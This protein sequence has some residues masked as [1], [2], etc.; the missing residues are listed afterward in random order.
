MTINKNVLELLIPKDKE[1]LFACIGTDRSTGD[2]LGPLVGTAL[3]V[4]GYTVMGTLHFPV[5]AMNLHETVENIERN[6]PSHFIVA[7]DACLGKSE[8]VGLITVKKGSIKP[9][10]A[11]GKDLPLIGDVAITGIVNVGGFMEASVLQSTRLSKVMDM[12]DE[13]AYMCDAAMKRR[14]N[15]KKKRP[16]V[17]GRKVKHI[18]RTL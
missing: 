16:A 7:V 9:G 6:Y 17:T 11:V 14:A 2:S 8:R 5:H 10:L 13:I 3:S 1:V 12:A 15:K 4:M 18:S